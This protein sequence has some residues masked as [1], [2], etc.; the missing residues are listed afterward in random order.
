MSEQL[1][2]LL[3]ALGAAALLMF[4]IVFNRRKKLK[5]LREAW[6][7]KADPKLFLTLLED[8]T[9]R[10]A[11]AP[12]ELMAMK[13][14]AYIALGEGENAKKL[15]RKLDTALLG[16]R[17]RITYYQK[18]ASFFITERDAPEAEKSIDMLRQS[19]EM[20]GN[21]EAERMLLDQTRMMFDVFIKKD[22]SLIDKLSELERAQADSPE[23]GMSRYLLA[24]LYAAAG[25]SAKAG[26]LA[27]GAAA[28]L[29]GTGWEAAALA[30]SE[31]QS[32]LLI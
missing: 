5:K 32:L 10:T 29:K 24:R 19:I 27:A 16:K 8:K 25:D 23:R 14:D 26:E 3:F 1:K 20:A 28:L 6:S 30:A 4:L 13:L 17:D 9:A 18:R 12:K 7:Q 31:D 11:L 22:V 21:G 2:L 15:I